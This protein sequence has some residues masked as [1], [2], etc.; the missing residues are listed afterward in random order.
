MNLV[1]QV[2][3]F[4]RRKST[5]LF[6]FNVRFMY[7]VFAMINKYNN[8]FITGDMHLGDVNFKHEE[9]LIEIFKNNKFD[10]IVFG[11]DTFDPWRGKSIEELLVEY[12]GFFR[13]L[14]QLDAL[15]VFIRGNHDNNIGCLSEMGFEVR[16]NFKYISATGDRVGVIHGHEFDNLVGKFE[17][18]SRK[19]IYI[20]EKLNRLLKAFGRTEPLRILQSFDTLDMLRTM[21]NFYKK[22][23]VWQ[24]N[25]DAL[26]FG[27]LHMPWEGQ[28]GKI[29][30]YNWGSWQKDYGLRPRYIKNDAEGFRLC[31]VR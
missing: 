26:V 13:F 8:V 25:I 10:C 16:K 4:F 27:H 24:Q 22:I 30:F 12:K 2:Y 11:G 5:R 15:K 14:Q 21:D 3:A 1:K 9:K 19:V 29:N 23:T 31:E 18:I 7:N 6:A 20:E 28:R 17:F